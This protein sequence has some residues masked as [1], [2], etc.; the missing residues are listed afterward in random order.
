VGRVWPPSSS[1]S[2]LLDPR[3]SLWRQ[4]RM[5]SRSAE[6]EADAEEAADLFG[7]SSSR[8]RRWR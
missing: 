8:Q 3:R 4:H 5:A 2:S 6:A 1:S 7:R